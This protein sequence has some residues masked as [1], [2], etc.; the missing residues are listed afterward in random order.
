MSR[1]IKAFSAE[2]N[3][4]RIGFVLGRRRSNASGFHLDKRRPRGGRQGQKVAVKREAV[5]A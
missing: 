5:A 1:T 3:I 4:D 2:S